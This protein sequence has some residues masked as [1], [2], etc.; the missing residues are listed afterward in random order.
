M[1]TSSTFSFIMTSASL[2]PGNNVRPALLP[3]GP[4]ARASAAWRKPRR[5]SIQ[6]APLASPLKWVHD[7]WNSRAADTRDR[8]HQPPAWAKHLLRLPVRVSTGARVP[9]ECRRLIP[10]TSRLHGSGDGSHAP[11]DYG[12]SRG[13]RKLHDPV[14]WQDAR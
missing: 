6:C 7:P 5:A 2:L 9:R 11:A 1:S 12:W 3:P 4:E 10:P 8:L 14:R 13:W